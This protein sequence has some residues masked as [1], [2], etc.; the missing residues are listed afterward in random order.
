VAPPDAN[1]FTGGVLFSP[2]T[3]NRVKTSS[4][5][6]ADM[7]SF[8]ADRV[9][10]TL[11]A[12]DQ[13]IQ[14]YSYDYN[15]G[16]KTSGYDKSAVTP[17][18]GL[19]VKPW[20]QVSLYAN[21]IEG[22]IQGDVAPNTVGSVVVSNAGEVFSPFKSKQYEVG[23][24]YDHGDIGGTLAV[25]RITEPSS[26]LAGNVYREDGEQRNQ[27]IE[28]S[29]YGE[30]LTGVRVL[31][32]VTLLDAK[33][34]KTQDGTLN[35]KKVIGVPGT[36]VNLGVE[37]D[38]AAVHGLTLDGRVIYTGSEPTDGAN[39]ESIPAWTRL[40]IGARYAL[41]IADKLV[42]VR[43]NVDNVTDKDYWASAGGA[44]GAN[45]LVLAA[46]RTFVL[47]LSVDF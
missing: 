12:R 1:F 36:E 16:H 37:W 40:D 11:G 29:W 34:A 32:G 44:P 43:A 14:Q 23:A 22:L 17:L 30:L 4:V 35:G 42:T 13:K 47:S 25:F 26:L 41:P 8:D 24:K 38:V 33:T 6:L 3:T 7:L 2:L 10:L 15:T 27:G 20:K 46:P 21:Y 5:A 31:G 9:L 18:V 19:V 39:T 28:L 45:Y